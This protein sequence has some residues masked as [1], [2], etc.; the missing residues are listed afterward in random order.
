MYM[1]TSLKIN[2]ETKE[3]K[4]R[5]R[6]VVKKLKGYYGRVECYL[7]HKNAFEL[8]CAVA[9]SAQCTDERVNMTTPALFKKYPNPE[10]LAAAKQSEVEKIIKPCGFY[11]NK[12]K[13]LIAMAQ[14]LV[15]HHDGEV[16]DKMDDLVQ[17]GGVGR[18]TANVVLGNWFG[19]SDGVVVD[20]HVKRICNLMGLTEEKDPVKI[21]QD[22][23][24]IVPKKDWDQFSLWLI[25]HGRETCIARRP[26]CEKCMLAK[27][28]KHVKKTD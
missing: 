14:R 27:W 10:K 1:P 20:T 16:P 21:E 4:K 7:T 23:N 12:S 19:K 15:S 3:L 13:N 25:A 17:L 28:C 6:S 9:L 24:K 26:Q 2:D 8:I 18:K 11:K 22:L 5:T